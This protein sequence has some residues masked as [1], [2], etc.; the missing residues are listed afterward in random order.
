[1]LTSR[2]PSRAWAALSANY[3]SGFVNG[4]GPAHLPA[5]SIWN[6]AAGKNWTDSLATSLNVTNL[7][8]ASYL[9][10]NSNTF[11]GTHW[12]LPRQFYF[13]L[14]WRLHY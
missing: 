3:G 7:T 13:E 8:N 5:N 2:L 6:L 10:D 9:L 14:R 4:N 12:Q 1:M 11:G